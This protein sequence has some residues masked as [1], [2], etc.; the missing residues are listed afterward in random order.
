MSTA[1][2]SAAMVSVYDGRSCIGF[3]FARGKL[4][5]EAF[6]ADERSVGTFATKRD[7]ANA[8]MA[9]RGVS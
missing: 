2:P 1:A 7:A 9:Q 5:L 3:I 8:L 6:T 4:G